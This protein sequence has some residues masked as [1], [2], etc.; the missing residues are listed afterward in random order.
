MLSHQHHRVSFF[1]ASFSPS[2]AFCSTYS[3]LISCCPHSVLKKHHKARVEEDFDEFEEDI[4]D[5][6]DFEE[7]APAS[8][9]ALGRSN[10]EKYLL[11]QSFLSKSLSQSHFQRASNL[12][13]RRHLFGLLQRTT[14]DN[15]DATLAILA[16]WRARGPPVDDHISR[17]VIDRLVALQQWD[18]LLEVLTDRTKY[19]VELSSA[20]QTDRVFRAIG[21]LPPSQVSEEALTAVTERTNRLLDLSRSTL[22]T[23]EDPIGPL[24]A[25]YPTLRLA[26]ALPTEEKWSNK[27]DELIASLKRIGADSLEQIIADNAQLPNKFRVAFVRTVG[28][29]AELLEQDEKRKGDAAWFREVAQKLHK[30]A[31]GLAGR[32]Q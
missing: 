25:L 19:G 30:Y 21:A 11:V 14:L 26:Q 31:P 5:E 6:I 7:A 4:I 10:E 18:T 12:P 24:S 2:T 13:A 32:S 27:V 23:V 29:V 16:Q 3:S 9:G 17:K 15:L 28:N 1:S 8:P 20:R 22:T